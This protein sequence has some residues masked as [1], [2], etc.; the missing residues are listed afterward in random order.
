MNNSS[1]YTN[2]PFGK[3]NL[4]LEE[5][6]KN[7]TEEFFNKK[8]FHRQLSRKEIFLITLSIITLILLSITVYISSSR[9]QKTQEIRTKAEESQVTFYLFPADVTAG[10]GENFSIS[11]KLVVSGDKKIASAVIS[12][13]FDKNSLQIQDFQKGPLANHLLNL[14]ST[15]LDQ[16]NSEG[17]MKILIGADSIDNA[18]GG[19]I[20]LPKLDFIVIKENNT[21]IQY[22]LSSLQIALTT[23]QTAKINIDQPVNIFIPPPASPILLLPSVNEIPPTATAS[24]VLPSLTPIL[25]ETL[26]IEPSIPPSTSQT[27]S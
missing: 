13:T 5:Y 23:N 18:P 4:K 6:Y 14:K 8:V 7:K 3:H 15:P 2:F 12:L 16:A 19:S 9:Q 22:D 1:K 10:N 11:P 20:D 17:K 27:P 24:P 26:Q 21:Q 25:H